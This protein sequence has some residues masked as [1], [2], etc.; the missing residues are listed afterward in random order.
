MGV[1]VGR[2]QSKGLPVAGFGLREPLQAPE[3]GAKVV[4]SVGVGRPQLQRGGSWPLLQPA[5]QDSRRVTPR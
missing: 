2:I 5:D 3:R 4:V 1:V